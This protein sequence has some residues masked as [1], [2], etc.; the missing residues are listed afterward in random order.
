MIYAGSSPEARASFA[1]A[2]NGNELVWIM[3]TL[4]AGLNACLTAEDAILVL[5]AAFSVCYDPRC[6]LSA[7][8]NWSCP[9]SPFRCDT[10]SL[11]ACTIPPRSDIASQ[12]HRFLEKCPQRMKLQ[13]PRYGLGCTIG[14][15][16]TED[17]SSCATWQ[18]NAACKKRRV[19]ILRPLQTWDH[20]LCKQSDCRQT[21]A[22][23]ILPWPWWR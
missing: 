11:S 10:K 21:E 18:T 1:L 23:P 20:R 7:R 14:K 9:R 6:I 3:T 15:R 12:V 19:N 16:S 17:L 5:S 8:G 22:E 2:R 13:M 4:V